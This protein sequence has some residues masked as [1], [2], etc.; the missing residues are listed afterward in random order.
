MQVI[1]QL[2]INGYDLS[3]FTN[4]QATFLTALVKRSYLD[5]YGD[6]KADVE[7]TMWVALYGHQKDEDERLANESINPLE[8]AAISRFT[9]D[10]FIDNVCLSI[11]HDFPLLSHEDK[12]RIR[13]ECKNWMQAI[14]NNWSY[15]K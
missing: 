10:A 7:N 4:E 9:T 2:K 15:H 13:R 6:G 8:K 3:S 5:G 11:R 12:E 14:L 1:E